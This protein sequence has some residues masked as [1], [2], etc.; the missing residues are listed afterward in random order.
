M[1]KPAKQVELEDKRTALEKQLEILQNEVE[2]LNGKVQ[3]AGEEVDRTF[4]ENNREKYKDVDLADLVVVGN[5]SVRVKTKLFEV[6][7]A[8]LSKGDSLEVDKALKNY[9]D[10]TGMY[11][12]N[13]SLVL[14]LAKAI[15][16][17]GVPDK[18]V[19]VP[20]DF[21]QAVAAVQQINEVIFA[22]LWKEYT[23]FT[24]WINCGLRFSLKNS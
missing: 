12:Q 20:K 1:T 5:V 8:N 22:E 23:Q 3:L 2:T 21:V 4:F 6:E 14:I 9:R 15:R 16:R 13:I 19:P 17:F 18:T 7:I 11:I 10:E 24:R